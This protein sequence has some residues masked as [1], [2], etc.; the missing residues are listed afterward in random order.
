MKVFLYQRHRTTR[1]FSEAVKN[2]SLPM[3]PVWGH[4]RTWKQ[5]EQIQGHAKCFKAKSAVILDTTGF[6]AMAT[7]T[8][9]NTLSSNI[10]AM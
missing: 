4:L 1:P 10:L 8:F 2:A 9:P 3:E 6:I 5:E 7:E